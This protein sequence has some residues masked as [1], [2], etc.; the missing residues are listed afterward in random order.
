MAWPAFFGPWSFPSA[1][2]LAAPITWQAVC[3]PPHHRTSPHT[4]CAIG[5]HLPSRRLKL[6]SFSLSSSPTQHN[7]GEKASL[8]SS[9]QCCAQVA[10]GAVAEKKCY[11]SLLVNPCSAEQ[12][13]CCNHGGSIAWRAPALSDQFITLIARER[14]C[15]PPMTVR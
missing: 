4:R 2:I 1:Y 15:G 6:N 5:S 10:A 12:H 3:A 13:R 14:V 9:S 7:T 11:T 8:F